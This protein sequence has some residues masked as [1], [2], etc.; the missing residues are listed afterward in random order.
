LLNSC[1]DKLDIQPLNILSSDMVFGNEQAIIAY[2]ASL[3]NA[4]QVED[5]DFTGASFLGNC[6]DEANTSFSNEALNIG[7][8]TN[9]QWWG[10]SN[11]R[12]VNDLI[13]KLPA[14]TVGESTKQT[15]MGEA[16]FIRAHYYFTMVKRY[17]GVPIIT[18]V[19]SFTGN[20]IAELQVARNT[21][22]QV[23]DFIAADLDQAATLLPPTNIKGRATKYAALALK[24]RAMLYA[25]SSAKYGSVQLAGLMGIPA[26]DANKYWQAAYD[27]ANAVILSGVYSLYKVNS[28][29]AV[30]FQ[31]LFFERGTNTEAIFTKYYSYPDKTH[32][33]DVSMIPF[34]IRQSNGY[35]SMMCPTLDCVEQFEYID[36]SAGKL[37]I[38]TPS[39]PIFYNT[40]MDLFLN[41]DPRFFGSVIVP[42]EVFKGSIIDIQSG[43]Y[44]QGVKVEAGDYSALYN[45]VTH[46]ADNVNGTLH[47]V[48]MSGPGGSE[49]TLTGFY[50]KKYLDPNLAQG[51]LTTADMPWMVLRYGEVLLNYAE[52]AVELG[53]IS[54]AKT[55]INLI[56]ARAGIIA[57]ADADITID[58][59]R[60]ERNNEL[61]FENQRWWDYRRWHMSTILFNNFQPKMLKTYYD[62]QQKKYRFETGNAGRYTKTFDVKV[63]YD[64]IDPA[65]LA[66]T[67]NLVQNP[68]Y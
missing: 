1:E 24:S 5:F 55:A 10:Y 60:K 66:K 9:T 43:L 41:K 21:E 65:E 51:L 13:A 18:E 47:I 28:D 62:V 8:G 20:N 16:Y 26:A 38:G 48:G 33:W 32:R 36:G 12:N 44:D 7:N 67:P 42:F 29:K 23:Y 4:M 31:Q 54:D 63:Y 35:S 39:S 57:L 49:K 52:A 56:R 17:G 46:Q 6:T 58:R 30:N 50:M 14:S 19:Q 61:A 3:Y 68:G 25:A 15:L 64:R 22:Q 59:V 27:A 40:P 37:N 45:P 2:M 53:K 11:V 34:G